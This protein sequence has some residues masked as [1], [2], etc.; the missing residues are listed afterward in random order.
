[1]RATS[2][3]DTEENMCRVARLSSYFVT[4]F[5]SE[6]SLYDVLGGVRG[7]CH[8][9]F[10]SKMSV[11]KDG[12]AERKILTPWC[13]CDLDTGI[14]GENMSTRK[15]WVACQDAK[16]VVVPWRDCRLHERHPSLAPSPDFSPHL[17]YSFY[18]I[19]VLFLI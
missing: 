5:I 9:P 3:L 2:S 15:L 18:H 13:L 19:Y 17:F 12:R 8:I 1:M 14:D 4:W 6:V 10:E 16:W 7:T 11:Y